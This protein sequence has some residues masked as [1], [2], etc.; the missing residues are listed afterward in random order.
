MS[1][2]LGDIPWV[3]DLAVCHGIQAAATSAQ[4][5]RSRRVAE[6]FGFNSRVTD[7]PALAAVVHGAHPASCIARV[8]GR[9]VTLGGDG[10]IAETPTGI[11]AANGIVTKND[12]VASRV[13]ENISAAGAALLFGRRDILVGLETGVVK[14]I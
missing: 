4:F 14:V 13:G 9:V 5:F 7:R 6:G 2:N 11:V 8:E 10:G 1:W 3:D 12:S